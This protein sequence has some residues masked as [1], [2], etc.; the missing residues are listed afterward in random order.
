MAW[1]HATREVLDSP[2]LHVRILLTDQP[3]RHFGVA[4]V[5]LVDATWFAIP[6][7]RKTAT[8][9]RFEGF[10]HAAQTF[11]IA[12]SSGTTGT[13]KLM[14]I[15]VENAASRSDP[16][17]LLDQS[18][19][20]CVASYFHP[21]HQGNMWN[22]LRVLRKGGSF[23]FGGG[24]AVWIEAGAT[25]VI[26]SPTHYLNDR[27]LILAARMPMIDHAWI[28]GGPIHAHQLKE[29]LTAFRVVH[30]TYGASEVGIVSA[31]AITTETF[32]EGPVMLG[33]VDPRCVLEIVDD[34]GNPLPPGLEGQL[35]MMTP[36]LVEGYLGDA[37]TTAVHFK[38]GWYH[39]GDTGYLD[40]AGE[41]VVTG[42]VS[43]GVNLQGVKLNLTLIDEVINR[44]RLVRDALSFV[45]R[46]KAGYDRLY[47]LLC[48][49]PGADASALP[50]LLSEIIGKG[51][52]K[53]WVPAAYYAVDAIPRNVNGKGLRENAKALRVSAALLA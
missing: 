22:I 38:A 40:S 6:A 44:H 10:A 5:L 37:E 12:Q 18:A 24:F 1:A 27:D 29:L 4:N 46:D 2:A 39:P 31:K 41:L 42:R 47:V 28:G 13:I 7:E 32:R 25:Y 53:S 26:G 35:R 36:W 50:A 48:P 17:L 8:A 43:D 45:D 14:R 19:I 11:M 52:G 20:P 15:S 23:L 33:T 16:S 34:S 3:G 49:T 51:Y 21:L 9:L 30:V